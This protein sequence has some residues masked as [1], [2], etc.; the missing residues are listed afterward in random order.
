V[1]YMDRGLI[2]VDAGIIRSFRPSY[3]TYRP[4]TDDVGLGSLGH[5]EPQQT[6]INAEVDD[7][8]PDD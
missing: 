5:T 2:V 4:L 3:H 1:D 6:W 7:H 8:R